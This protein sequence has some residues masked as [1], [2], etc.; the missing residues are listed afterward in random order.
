M[1]GIVKRQDYC[2]FLLVTQTNY[3]LTY[4]ANHSQNFSHDAPTRYLRRDRVTAKQV[5][6]EAKR[7]LVVSHNGFIIFDDSILDKN[8]SRHIQLV[9]KQYSGNE[10]RVI[11]GIGLINCVYV[12]PE[13][14]EFWVIDYRIYDP[15]TDGKDKH[16]HVKD[17][18]NACFEKCA[19][20]E[21]A[22][23]AVLMDT[24]YATTKLMLEIHRS[25]RL[26]YCPIQ[27]NRRVSEVLEGQKYAYQSAESVIWTLEEVDF[28]KRVHL[29]EFPAG[30]ELKLFRIAT[31]AG[32]SASPKVHFMVKNAIM[33]GVRCWCGR[34]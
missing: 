5:W 33:W 27:D 4:F 20:E 2:Q 7:D 9:Y 28:G 32:S 10:H 26:F 8:H 15:S 12:N 25:G 18:L 24:W 22:F 14:G 23:K 29:K 16:Q 34:F 13:T 30:L 6:I 19:R 1:S 11:R 3:T 17:M 31:S 21:L